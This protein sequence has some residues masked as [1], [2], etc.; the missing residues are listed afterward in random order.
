MDTTAHFECF[1]LLDSIKVAHSFARAATP[2][3]KKRY[4]N[5][6]MNPNT[7]LKSFRVSVA[8]RDEPA[9]GSSAG[10]AFVGE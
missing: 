6:Q 4:G 7:P 5:L 3:L 2:W 10:H 1:V 8:S 9:N